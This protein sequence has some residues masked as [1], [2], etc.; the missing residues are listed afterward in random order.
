MNKRKKILLFA[1]ILVVTALVMTVAICNVPINSEDLLGTYEANTGT[2]N[3][4]IVI[5]PDGTF[6][7]T[8]TVTSPVIKASARGTWKYYQHS[9]YIYFS[10]GLLVPIDRLGELIEDFAHNPLPGQSVKS[11]RRG[12]YGIQLGVHPALRFY[13]QD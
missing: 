4:R 6:V 5:N 11:V 9:G 8:V 2:I 1:G 13:K 12:F 10:A 7:Q 3:N